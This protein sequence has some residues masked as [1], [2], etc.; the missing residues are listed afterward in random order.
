M[1]ASQAFFDAYVRCALWSS[2][3]NSIVKGGDSHPDSN[4]GDPL[5]DNYG[6]DDIAPET[7]ASMRKDC[8]AFVEANATDLASLIGTR[9]KYHNGVYDDGDAGHDYW[10]S[11]NGHG[12]G[13]FD[14]G[15][16]HGD[17]W[18]RLQEAAERFGEVNLY[19]DEGRVHA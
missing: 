4:G 15:E 17:A 5:D 9:P 6:P 1:P 13:F 16:A 12:A 8:D 10:L 19:V 11:R 3:D 7:L 18:D 14:N 2:T